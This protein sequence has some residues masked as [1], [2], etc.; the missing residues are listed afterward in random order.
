MDRQPYNHAQQ[1]TPYS[2]NKPTNN[3]MPSPKCKERITK[4]EHRQQG[5]IFSIL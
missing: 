4:K 2:T 3:P 5:F 1:P